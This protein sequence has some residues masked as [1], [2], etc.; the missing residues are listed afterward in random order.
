MYWDGAE[1]F[2]CRD[3]LHGSKLNR[4]QLTVF[5]VNIS[6]LLLPRKKNHLLPLHNALPL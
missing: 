4:L 2:Y 6:Y 1:D 3:K 5:N